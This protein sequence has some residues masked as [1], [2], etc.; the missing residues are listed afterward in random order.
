MNNY[1]LQILLITGWVTILNYND[2]N[3]A[4]HYC[5]KIVTKA[6]ISSRVILNNSVILEKI[7]DSSVI[8]SNFTEY[9]DIGF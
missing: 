1:E 4:S 2:L 7:Y 3:K 9:S 5:E 8:D 6:K